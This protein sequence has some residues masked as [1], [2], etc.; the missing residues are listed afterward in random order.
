MKSLLIILFTLLFWM[1]ADIVISQD[2]PLDM[3]TQAN[4]AYEIGDYPTA[5]RL[6]ENIVAQGTYDSVV[7]FN[8]GNAYYQTRDL[9]KT[10]VNYLRAQQIAPRDG[11]LNA[12]LA[13]VRAQRL[14]IQG[15]STGIIDSIGD[16]TIGV[17]AITELGWGTF[18]WW[19]LWFGL[20]LL[21]IIRPGWRVML[22]T[23]LMILG[24][25]LLV[26]LILFGS[27]LYTALRRPLAVIIAKTAPAMSGPGEQY[28]VNFELHTAAE[29]RVLDMREDWVLFALPDD[30]QGWV[31]RQAI[32]PV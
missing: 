26:S 17:F 31:S 22:R 9:G 8:L 29:I 32:E 23:P 14:D 7:F 12:N 4:E 1:S 5:I 16:L 15:D 3:M 10:M 20:L 24:F 25:I 27:R 19:T 6:Y 2:T 21:T 30:R 18:V 11:E 28:L 13:L